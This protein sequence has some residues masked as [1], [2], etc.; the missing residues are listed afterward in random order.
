MAAIRE[1][2]TRTA[3]V[4]TK[5]E[6][7]NW[8]SMAKESGGHGERR[9]RV[10]QSGCKCHWIDKTEVRGCFLHRRPPDSKVAP[11]HRRNFFV[12]GDIFFRWTSWSSIWGR[13]RIEAIVVGIGAAKRG[14]AKKEEVSEIGAASTETPRTEKPHPW[15]HKL[16]SNGQCETLKQL[17]Q[18]NETWS[19]SWWVHRR[20][21]ESMHNLHGKRQPCRWNKSWQNH[22]E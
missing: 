15:Q 7:C 3:M 21:G 5:L 2:A 1:E 4:K 11:N 18:T 22:H 13:H 12:H 14:Q 10:P 9:T 17:N 16:N 8:S 6:L 20:E 19:M